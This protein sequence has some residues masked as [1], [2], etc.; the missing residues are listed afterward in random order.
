[1]RLVALDLDGTVID[2][3]QRLDPQV[4]DAVQRLDSD[5]NTEVVIATGRSIDAALAIVEMLSI[6]PTWVI[7]ANGA[8]VLRRDALADRAYRREFVETFDTTSVLEQIWPHLMH[9][10]YAVEDGNGQIWHTDFIPDTALPHNERNVTFQDLLGIQASRVVVASPGQDLDEFLEIVERIGLS[11]VSYAIGHTAWLDLAPKGVS[12]AT[13][14]QRVNS[15]LK[16][17]RNKIFAAGDGDNDS[18][19]LDWVGKHGHAV[20]MGQAT[21]AVKSHATEVTG[22]VAENGLL[23]ALEKW[24]PL[25]RA[26]AI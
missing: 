8:I 10:R 11:T 1:M 4:A 6:T 25:L 7:S 12:K 20:V 9:A 3:D 5:P 22:T 26:H 15:I 13:A 17:E 14:L 24:H 18:E 16:V 21:D 19:M 23:A 2:H